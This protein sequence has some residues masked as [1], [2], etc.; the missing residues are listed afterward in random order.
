MMIYRKVL[1]E[2]SLGAPSKRYLV[3]KP[4]LP[5]YLLCEEE[6]GGHVQVVLA[7]V[8]GVLLFNG[9]FEFLLAFALRSNFLKFF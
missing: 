4:I 3:R 7:G 1:S 5:D 2:T 9:S 8:G 6:S